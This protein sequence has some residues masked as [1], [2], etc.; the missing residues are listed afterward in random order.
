MDAPRAAVG[1]RQK[2]VSGPLMSD[3]SPESAPKPTSVDRSRSHMKISRPDG[4]DL[5]WS[6]LSTPIAKN[7]SVSY[8]PKSPAYPLPSRPTQE[9]YRDRHGRGAGCGGRGWRF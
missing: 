8:S 4:L 1:N 5:V 9:A 2:F 7:I 3:L 6:R